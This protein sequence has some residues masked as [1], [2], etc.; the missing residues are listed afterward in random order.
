M[1]SPAPTWEARIVFPGQ[2]QIRIEKNAD[3][4][5]RGNV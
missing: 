5:E 2:N 4:W 3:G 1:E